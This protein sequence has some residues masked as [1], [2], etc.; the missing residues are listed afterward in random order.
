LNGKSNIQ[1]AKEVFEAIKE[2]GRCTAIALDIRGYFDHIDHIKLKEKWI[3]VLKTNNL[4]EDEYKVFKTL[5]KYS[6]INKNTLLKHFKVRLKDFKKKQSTLIDFVALGKTFN[7][8]LNVLRESNLITT[9]DKHELINDFKR[10]YGIPQ[11]SSL[12]ALLS[13]IYLVDYDKYFTDRS[14]KEGFIYRRYCDDILIICDTERSIALQK[15]AIEEIK[16]YHLEIQDKKV[17]RIDFIENSFKKIRAFNSIKKKKSEV[18][19][20]ETNESKFYKNLQYLGFEF[21]GQNI[22]IRASSLSRYFRKMK[23]RISKTVLMAYSKNTKGDK[24]FKQQLF[25]RYTH[26]GKRNFLHYAYN[27]SKEYYINSEGIRK[28]GMNSESIRNQLK[29]HFSILLNCLKN[30]NDQHGNK[31]LALNRIKR[32]KLV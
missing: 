16:K 22:F 28:D 3:K 25:H 17:D 20:D 12:S 24:I 18:P 23:S 10:Y 1:F 32:K 30:K 29:R 27:S 9:N 26:L 31:K 6:Y 5:T 14:I 19:I 21:N 11:G 8:K 7:E 4:L 2:K 13:N 15:D